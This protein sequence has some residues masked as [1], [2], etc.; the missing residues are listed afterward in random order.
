MSQNCV[1]LVLA[2]VVIS[3]D[4]Y[5]IMLNVAFLSVLVDVFICVCGYDP[6]K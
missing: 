2:R 1:L 4:S 6:E 5:Y 3:R